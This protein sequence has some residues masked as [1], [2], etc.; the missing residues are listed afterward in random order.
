MVNTGEYMWEECESE[1]RNEKGTK[2]EQELETHRTRQGTRAMTRVGTNVGTGV[3]KKTGAAVGA[4]MG[5]RVSN[6]EQLCELSENKSRK[7]RTSNNYVNS[8]RTNVGVE[9]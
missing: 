1:G 4:R 3:G 6:W 2:S 8:V 5:T 7:R 9:E